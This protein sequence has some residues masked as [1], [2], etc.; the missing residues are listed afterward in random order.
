[1][2]KEIGGACLIVGPGATGLLFA[3][4]LGGALLDCRADRAKRLNRAGVC[5]ES[6]GFERHFDPRVYSD[7]SAVEFEPDWVLFAVKAYST[8]EAAAF[9]APA[10][11]PNAYAVTLQNGVGNAEILASAYGAERVLAGSTSEGAWLVREG[12]ARHAGSGTTTVGALSE[13]S[14]EA[15]ERFAGTL[16]AAGFDAKTAPDWEAS[17]WAKAVVNA[18]VNPITALLGVPNGDVSRIQPLRRLAAR[19]VKEASRAAEARGVQLPPD[20]PKRMLEVCQKT[21]QNRSSMLQDALRGSRTELEQI[22]GALLRE[23]SAHGVP[24]PALKALTELARAQTQIGV[25]V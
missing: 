20:L 2:G 21:A 8:E 3:S 15:A 23:A 12:V 6:R 22:N 19:V 13:V 17:V 10:V 11:S 1:M 9:A 5:V 4:R 14:S 18:A 16:R 25:S 24:A 7:P